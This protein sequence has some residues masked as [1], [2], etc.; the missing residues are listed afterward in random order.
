M[1]AVRSALPAFALAAL[2][3]FAPSMARS[4]GGRA[5]SR[6]G[7][8]PS[9]TCANCHPRTVEQHMQSHHETSFMNPLFQAQYFEELLPKASRDPK[10]AEEARS[11]TACHA[12]VAFATQKTHF[13][14]EMTADPSMS[15]VTCDLCHTISGYEG[16]TPRNG[17]FISRPSEQK[18]GPF[19]SGT[20]WHHVYSELQ[21]KSEFCAT[22]HEAVNHNGVLVKGTYSEWKKSSFAERGVQC[23]DC[24]MTR[25]GFQVESGSRFESGAAAQ[26]GLFKAPIRDK[27]YT[28][29]FPGAHARAQVEGAIAVSF[30]R[31][32]EQA[33]PG[34]T[35]A[36][37]IQVDNHRTGHRMPSGSADLRLLWLEVTARAGPKSWPVPARAKALGGYSVA[38]TGDRDPELLSSDVPLGARTY[39]AVYFDESGRQTLSSYEAARIVWDNRL[40]PGERRNEAY[41][42]TIPAEVR[43]TL[44]LEARLVYLSFPTW[45]AKR[46]EV[47]A[48]EPIQVAA[49]TA[50]VAV[51]SAPH[52]PAVKRGGPPR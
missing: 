3:V 27:L 48:A 30:V 8:W 7:Y 41:E 17:N 35:V 14:G 15:G 12:P 29:R 42:F 38:G 9:A 51:S 47:R 39:R 49:A 36:F 24:H 31:P 23:Q 45:L 6:T 32:P 40:D 18:L 11:C 46:M 22:C 10:L 34:D 25:D 50:Q 28:H 37:S 26:G 5:P 19:P 2:A 1:A 21:T 16:P 13:S 33:G 52:G 44:R 4:Q 43:G 20:N